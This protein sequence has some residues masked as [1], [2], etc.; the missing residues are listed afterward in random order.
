MKTIP[1]QFNTWHK[2]RTGY[3]VMGLVELLLAFVA[4][5]RA[6]DT[7]SGWEYL[8]VFILAVGSLQNLAKLLRPKK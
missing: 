7:G 3:I 5:S 6:W 1:R 4:G 8:A 2:T